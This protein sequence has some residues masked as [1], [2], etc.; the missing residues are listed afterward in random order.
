MSDLLHQVTEASRD[1]LPLGKWVNA[2]VR[3]LL[4]H[5]AKV[6]DSIG[7]VVESFAESIEHGLLAIPFWAMILAATLVG[8]RRVGGSVRISVFEAG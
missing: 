5:G 3:Y 7:I 1:L 2:A 4:D 8:V 6:F